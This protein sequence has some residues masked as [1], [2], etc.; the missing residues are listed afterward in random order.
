MG[1]KLQADLSIAHLCACGWIFLNVC[2]RI[3]SQQVEEV[4]KNG[5]KD[6]SFKNPN[7]L[8]RLVPA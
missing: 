2:F 7:V 8:G 5:M 6:M 1:L 4:L 3:S